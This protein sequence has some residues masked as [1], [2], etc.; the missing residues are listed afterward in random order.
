M[1]ILSGIITYN[2]DI[3]RLKENIRAVVNQVDQVLVIDNASDNAQDIWNLL[4]DFSNISLIKNTENLGVA[5]ALNQEAEY[6][7]KNGYEWI[8]SLDQDSV[9]PSGLISEYKKYTDDD[10]IGMVTCKIKDRNF[11]E[12]DYLLKEE[13]EIKFVDGCI[14][15]ASLLR[16]DAWEK[17]G[18]YYEPFFIDSVDFDLCSSLI[19][20]GYKILK[21]RNVTLLH[22]V[23]QGA[24]VHVLG[25]DRQLTNHSPLRYYYIYRNGLKYGKRHHRFLRI[26]RH[27]IFDFFLM[28]AFEKN[29]LEKDAMILKGIYH[30]IIGKYGKYEG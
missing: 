18:G 24:K 27:Y 20:F 22:E 14:T 17:V 7:I 19:E 23:G 5:H 10:E 9:A 28:N 26:L 15:S 25:K 13:Q 16:L 29:R 30:F 1:K 11:G 2:P 4:N 12:L 8:L 6:G 21:T 3:N